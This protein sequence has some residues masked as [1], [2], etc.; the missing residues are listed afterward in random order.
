MYEVQKVFF[1]ITFLRK[2]Q[3]TYLRK[4]KT[5]ETENSGFKQESTEELL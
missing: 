5:W 1:H 3:G 2:L 4:R